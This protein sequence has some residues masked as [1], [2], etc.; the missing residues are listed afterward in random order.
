MIKKFILTSSLTSFLVAG[1]FMP[2][3]A[4]TT[5]TPTSPRAEKAACMKAATAK[6]K[7]GLKM[8][9]NAYQA[10]LK[11]AKEAK[12]KVARTKARTDYKSAKKSAKEAFA[13]DRKICVAMGQK[14]KKEENKEREEGVIKLDLSVLNNSGIS[15]MARLKE[16]DGKVKVKVELKDSSMGSVHPIHIH[17]GSCAA[18]GAV[19]YPLTDVVNKKSET[20]LNVTLA[21][22]KSDLPLAINVHKSSA[23]S[24][25]YV[26][27]GNLAL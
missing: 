9:Q 20:I 13:A 3:M 4:Q 17:M 8:A 27:C 2:V 10:G 21:Q 18:L 1:S 16:E 25:V 14:E 5:A 12:D 15:G 26:A 11:A 7:D 22:L 24:G 6:K 19:K 23:E